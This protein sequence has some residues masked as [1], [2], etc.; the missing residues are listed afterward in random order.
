MGQHSFSLGLICLICV[1]CFARPAHCFGAGNIGT[2]S[3]IEGQNF[4]HGDLEDTLLTILMARAAGG[5]KF[6]KLDVKRVRQL[7]LVEK[8][9]LANLTRFIL[10][11]GFVITVRLSMSELSNMSA[12]RLSVSSCGFLDSCHLATEPRNSRSPP[13]GLDATAQKSTLTSRFNPA[14]ADHVM[15]LC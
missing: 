8:W 5:K 10:A 1:L 3:R 9:F 6:S 13:R 2:T 15:Q 4:R 12:P 14:F 11:I 7:K